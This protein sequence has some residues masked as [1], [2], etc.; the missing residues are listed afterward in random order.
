MAGRM[1]KW[2]GHRTHPTTTTTTYTYAQKLHTRIPIRANI[3]TGMAIHTYIHTYIRTHVHT[4][5]TREH[6]PPLAQTSTCCPLELT[7]TLK[8][9][10]TLTLT[11]GKWSRHFLMRKTQKGYRQ[12]PTKTLLSGVL[13]FRFSQCGTNAARWRPARAL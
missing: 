5:T 4:F 10:V 1:L 2:Y 11:R 8:L 3:L 13:F 9:T 7:L 6:A 12:P